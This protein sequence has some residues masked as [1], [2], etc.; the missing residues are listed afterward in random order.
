MG[1]FEELE[2]I[3]DREREALEYQRQALLQERQ[4]FHLE[5]LRAAEAR[6]RQQAQVQLQQQQQ[7]QQPQQQ[8]HQQQ[9]QQQQHQ[10]MHVHQVAVPAVAMAP[11]SYT[12]FAFTPSGAAQSAATSTPSDHSGAAVGSPHHPLSLIHFIFI[13]HSF[14]DSLI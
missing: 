12:G 13:D 6:A 14:I 10:Q 11:I 3:M 2:A 5:Q 9:Q 4:A 7:Q 8:Q 1:H